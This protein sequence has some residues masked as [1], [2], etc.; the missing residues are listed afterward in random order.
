MEMSFRVEKVFHVVEW[1]DVL[2]RNE[3]ER[4]L[5][6]EDFAGTSYTWHDVKEAVEN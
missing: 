2:G 3:R 5:H 6:A 1:R 4:K